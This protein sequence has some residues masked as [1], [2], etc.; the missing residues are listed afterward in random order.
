MYDTAVLL[1]VS[2]SSIFGNNFHIKNVRNIK[3]PFSN[4]KKKEFE[5]S[6]SPLLNSLYSTALRMTKNKQDAEDLVQETF[7]K[8]FR[9]FQ[10]F[11]RGTNF[12]AWIFKILV[13]TYISS[14]RKKV[15]EPYKLSYDRL[16]EFYL[17]QQMERVGLIEDKDK[18]LN[19]FLDDDVKGAL[20]SLPEQ[21]RVVILLSDLEGFSY[22]EISSI[23]GVPVGTVMSRLFRG[24]KILEKILWD[25]AKKRG[26]VKAER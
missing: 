17:Y 19:K 16:E 26:Y 23:V 13:N 8:A 12:K 20:D 2:F 4:D 11:E 9:S 5:N 7:L 21:F 15:K 3:M 24:R 14:Y 6:I 1:W 22:K 18:F 25:Y 10:Q